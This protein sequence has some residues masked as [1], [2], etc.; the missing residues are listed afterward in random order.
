MRRFAQNAKPPRQ[1]GKLKLKVR[2]PNDS[3]PVVSIDS[4]FSPVEKAKALEAVK[5]ARAKR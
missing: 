5:A 3:P 1:R 2:H 4:F